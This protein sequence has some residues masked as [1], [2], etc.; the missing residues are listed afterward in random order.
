MEV[1]CVMIWLKNI[2]IGF[3]ILLLIILSACGHQE[4]PNAHDGNISQQSYYDPL[5]HSKNQYKGMD[6]RLRE[7]TSQTRTDDQERLIPLE[8]ET[9]QK[10]PEENPTTDPKANH[11]KVKGIYVS[12]WIAGS[13][14][15]EK[16][17]KIADQTDINSMVI[18]VKND[19]GEITYD[20][21]V[22]LVNDFQSDR[23]K[24]IPNMRYLIK[25]LKDK[26]IYTIARIV[27]FKDPYFAGKNPQLA[28]HY[29]SGKLWRDKRGVLWVDPYQKKVWDYNVDIAKEAVDMGFDEIQFDYVRFPENGKKIDQEVQFY[30]AGGISKSQIISDFLT[31]ATRELRKKGAHVSADVFGLTTSTSDDMGIGQDWN[32]IT[33]VVDYISPMVYP[34]HYSSGMYGITH[35]DLEPY[36][37]V[38]KALEDGKE[39]NLKLTKAKKPAA[40]IRPW[41]QSFTARW[42]HPH[43]TYNHAEIKLQIKAAHEQGIDEYLLWNPK[44]EYTFR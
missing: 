5:E 17:M 12:G 42:I 2:F 44:C 21:N 32:Q 18:D 40:V 33:Q 27:V 1:G 28:M 3:L 43:Q 35:P 25:K 34:S 8:N 39:K 38:K 23:R 24:M 6:V 36:Q 26:N 22:S 15:M 4:D 10:S 20:S 30:Q 41:I 19:S 31:A 29:K 37:I 11:V 13:S 14:K 9:Q 16:L 7:K